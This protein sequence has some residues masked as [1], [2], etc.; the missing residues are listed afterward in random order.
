[1]EY[2]LLRLRTSSLHRTAD[3]LAFI[4]I[5]DDAYEAASALD[6]AIAIL[7]RERE[8]PNS[9]RAY[10]NTFNYDYAPRSLFDAIKFVA[11]HREQ[12]TRFVDGA[13]KPDKPARDDYDLL[14]QEG[15]LIVRSFRM[16]SPGFWEFI[17]AL[18]PLESLR[19]HLNDSHKRRQDQ[20]YRETA[21]ADR[22]A[23]ENERIR[24]ENLELADQIAY[25]RVEALERA[26]VS[27]K[28]LRDLT[29]RYVTRNLDRLDQLAERMD[30]DASE[31]I[32]PVRRSDPRFPW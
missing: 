5:L 16:N 11:G 26:G 8:L 28:E 13:V 21:E 7:L 25:R 3:L 18:N 22:L 1:M 15:R 27:K 9:F 24:L 2:G 29:R 30:I 19:N 14:E 31:R 23:L 4:R 12:I 20:E 32:E 17:G 6:D 10:A